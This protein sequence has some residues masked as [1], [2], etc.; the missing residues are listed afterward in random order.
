M[1][2]NKLERMRNLLSE[3]LAIANELKM[4]VFIISLTSLMNDESLNDCFSA[5]PSNSIVIL[6]DIDIVSAVKDRDKEDDQGV[7]MTGMLNVLDGFQSPPGVITIMTTNR[8]DVLDK[9]IIRP[10][11]VDIHEELGC[12]DD[13]QLRGLCEYFM[14]HIPD[15]L[16][17]I[18]PEDRITSAEVMGVIRRH[19][20]NFEEAGDD[21]VKFVE[22][23]LLTKIE[24]RSILSNFT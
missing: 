9:A 4:N 12:L 10:G 15:N 20:P 1:E 6:E 8:L 16:P 17:Y 11:R 18:T 24:E 14:D 13:Y 7:T 23:R 5:I 19:L 22:Q 21:V 3:D 2:K